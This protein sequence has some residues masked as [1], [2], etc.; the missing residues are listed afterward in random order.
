[1]LPYS[2][3]QH[4]F[5]ETESSGNSGQTP[6][7]K[8][9]VN[10]DFS[11][12]SFDI[13]ITEYNSPP[14]RKI[15]GNSPDSWFHSSGPLL[16]RNPYDSIFSRL[17]FSSGKSSEG[18]FSLGEQEKSVIAPIPSKRLFHRRRFRPSQKNNR[19]SAR[20]IS[21][22]PAAE[23]VV[24][25]LSELVIDPTTYIPASKGGITAAGLGILTGLLSWN[26]C[27]FPS[28]LMLNLKSQIGLF[29]R[30]DLLFLPFPEGCSW[31]TE[32]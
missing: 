24:R 16:L 19:G 2:A 12:D 8:I 11:E 6:H 17:W 25:F 4:L 5:G 27:S 15:H 22:I 32:G 13:N 29:V 7:E 23:R 20:A 28:R 21:E 26:N 31:Y 18:F 3:Y 9:S 10:E 14:I 30:P 1:M